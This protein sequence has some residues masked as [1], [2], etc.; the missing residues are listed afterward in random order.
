M[1]RKM[2]KKKTDSAA[3]AVGGIAV[4]IGSYVLMAA[5]NAFLAK[6]Q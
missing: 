1:F 2:I 5:V 3:S 6:K 4:L